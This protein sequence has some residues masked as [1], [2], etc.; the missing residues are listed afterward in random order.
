MENEVMYLNMDDIIPNRFQPREVF[1]EQ[2]LNELAESIRQH[3]VL[4]PILVRPVSNKF[5]IIA[6]ERRYKASAI[7]GLTK[8]PALIKNMDDKESSLVAFVENEQRRDVSVIEKARTSDRILK[9]HNMTQEELAKSLGIS[10][11]TLANRLRLL[12]LPLEVQ[13]ALMR[14]EISERHARS[15]LT[16]KDTEK[17]I[18]LLHKIKE[19]RMTVRELEG[20]IKAMYNDNQNMYNNMN[21]NSFMPNMNNNYNPMPQNNNGMNGFNQEPMANYNV[22]N[23][24]NDNFMSFLNNYDNSTASGNQNYMN[25]QGEMNATTNN[26][27]QQP[28][29]NDDSFM[30]FLQDYDNNNPVPAQGPVVD[31]PIPASMPQYDAV[32]LTGN[33]NNSMPNN[34]NQTPVNDFVNNNPNG[35][36]NGPI[37]SFN[38]DYLNNGVANNNQPVVNNEIPENNNDS[39]MNFL[40][41]YD[42]NYPTPANNVPEQNN[43]EPED[44]NTFLSNYD[45]NPASTMNNNN[46]LINDVNPPITT[47]FNANGY[48]EDNPNYVDVSTSPVMNSVDEIIGELKKTIDKI[49]AESKFKIDTDE[50]NFDDTY[51]ITIKIDKRDF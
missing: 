7:A 51:Q 37:M 49:K 27:N 42:A 3:G 31:A 30:K 8:I 35:V 40:N 14:N 36:N 18:E 11:S 9:S 24:N 23:Q 41:N 1:D 34:Y 28:A 33:M 32:P 47:N 48:V 5:E 44:L 39:F 20:E 22:N 38:N 45:N 16:V 17:Q 2:A 4:E 29:S 15:L 50:I 13:E 12:D 26:N 19:K 25:M 21:N 46:V 6:G 43:N 10:Q